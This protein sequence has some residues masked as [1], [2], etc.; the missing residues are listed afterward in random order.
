MK[1]IYYFFF[2]LI[3]LFS[4]KS[5]NSI[6][7]VW[8]GAY[9]IEYPNKEVSTIAKRVLFDFSDDKMITKYFSYPFM[10]DFGELEEQNYNLV[11]NKLSLDSGVLIVKSLTED[12]LVLYVEEMHCGV[13]L[14]LRRLTERNKKEFPKLR[15]RAFS[16]TAP[17]YA[18]SIDFINDTLF[19]D[20][21]N[22]PYSN[23][24]FKKWWVDSY[25]SYDFL[26][27]AMS[28]PVPYL[29]DNFSEEEI[30][31]KLFHTTNKNVKLRR[32][33][34][35]RDTLG[36]L[37]NWKGD[38]EY[39]TSSSEDRKPP[40][41][42]K[43]FGKDTSFYLNIKHDSLE[44]KRFNRSL[45]R[46]WKLNSTHDFIYFPNRLSSRDNV[47]KIK[48]FNKNELII[49]PKKWFGLDD[50]QEI[51]YKKQIDEKVE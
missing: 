28:F 38:L 22:N 15:N 24:H 39:S 26:I 42:P 1:R 4:F 19:L 45:K 16:I 47:W 34:N 11:G 33:K 51:K 7:G 17:N 21:G 36:L 49:E 23:H 27:L 14:V 20:I 50:K 6:K 31:L 29:I 48:E 35:K 30:D 3:L 25:K 12:S 32:I 40:I 9:H 18:D 44:T 5:E 8:M 2:G 41:P 37:G 13:D 43:F 46:K 10:P